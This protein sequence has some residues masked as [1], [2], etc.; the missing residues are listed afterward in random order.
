VETAPTRICQPLVGLP[1][2][3]VLGVESPAQGSPLVVHVACRQGGKPTVRRVA[4]GAG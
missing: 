2:V 1:E 3:D 4:A